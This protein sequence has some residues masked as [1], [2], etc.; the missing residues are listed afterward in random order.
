MTKNEIFYKKH[1]TYA[2][3]I[4]LND[5]H[6]YFGRVERMS[7]AHSFMYEQ[8]I[9]YKRIGII[10]I[11]HT[12]L[13]E[14]KNSALSKNGPRVHF[15]GTIRFQSNKS[16]KQFLLLEWY[17]ISRYAVLDIDTINDPS[18]WDSYCK[19]QEKIIN[20]DILTSVFINIDSTTV[21]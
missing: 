7:L 3:T 21:E 19:K 20:E 15:H 8:L 17:K 12:E 5:K 2:I 14:P 13:S 6:Q 9:H 18:I 11:L 4:N 1:T 16:V 10:I